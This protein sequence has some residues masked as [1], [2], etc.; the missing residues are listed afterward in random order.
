MVRMFYILVLPKS[1]GNTLK[2]TKKTLKIEEKPYFYSKGYPDIYS[3]VEK[4][5]IDL[6]G[7]FLLTFKTWKDKT[8]SFYRQLQPEAFNQKEKINTGEEKVNDD[9]EIENVE[10]EAIEKKQARKN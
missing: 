7:E 2:R 10:K 6:R 5:G 4:S 3:L 8:K 9:V 1:C